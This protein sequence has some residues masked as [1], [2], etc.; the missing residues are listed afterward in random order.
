M[1]GYS[2][3]QQVWHRHISE[4]LLERLP[5]MIKESE[6]SVAKNQN[7]MQI[8]VNTPV[9]HPDQTIISFNACYSLNE[10]MIQAVEWARGFEKSDTMFGV[11]QVYTK[12]AQFPLIGTEDAYKLERVGGTILSFVA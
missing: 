2:N 12:A 6:N 9:G 7:K 4:T 11:I 1:I 8:S 3:G 5:Y 10:R